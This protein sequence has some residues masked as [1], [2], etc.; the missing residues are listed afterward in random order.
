M[1]YQELENTFSKYIGVKDCVTTNTGTAA[2]H[3]AIE[4]KH[5]PLGAE[6]IVPEFSMIATALAPHYAGCIP[7]PVDCKEDMN[8]DPS[9]IERKITSK[10]VA[11]IITHVYGRVCE[12]DP[13]LA[14]CRKYNLDLIEDCCEAHG[15]VYI[16]GPQRGK[17]VGSLGIGCFSFYKNKIVS[18]EEGGAVCVANNS[19]YADH[20][21]DLKNM[22]F[23]K[24]H[25]YIH[26]YIGFNYRM[27][28]AQAEIA[29]NS[30][31]EIKHS[32]QKR[33]DIETIYSSTLRK[34]FLRPK[35]GCVWVYDINH[36][37]PKALV[38]YLN[39]EN[40][41]ARR[42]FAPMSMQPCLGIKG[43][44]QN[45]VSYKLYQNTCYLPVSEDL[46]EQDIIRICN[47]VNSF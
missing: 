15:S 38:S 13:I 45:L 39:S 33:R 24:D 34:E 23:G 9:L 10:T 43:E 22:S 40:I 12:V 25:N 47:K 31:N 32:L 37:N 18:A 14:L 27:S 5:Y 3:L 1:Y 44:Y 17:K 19:E 29:L 42:S 8:I 28:E 26:Q 11:I 41:A 20:L 4:G 2:L 46:E 6:V 7:V 36:K 21:R 16:D 35:R 30:L